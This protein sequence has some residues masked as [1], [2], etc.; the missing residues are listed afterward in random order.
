MK[1]ILL[2]LVLVLTLVGLTLQSTV[3]TGTCVDNDNDGTCADVD[4]NDSAPNR[5]Q[6]DDDGDGAT[7]CEG[8]CRDNDA[9]IH[10]CTQLFRVEPDYTNPIDNCYN[11]YEVIKEYS[12]QPPGEPFSQCTLVN[13]TTNSYNTCYQ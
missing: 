10:S 6:R 7:S 5:N 8:D 3:V 11:I 12:C 2:L 13:E 1:R 4:C 9:T